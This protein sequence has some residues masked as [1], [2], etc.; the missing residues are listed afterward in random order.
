M[1]AAGMRRRILVV[2]DEDLVRGILDLYLSQA[3]YVVMVVGSGASALARLEEESFDLVLTDHK[4]P[5]MTGTE[6][7]VVIK[8][9]WPALP[10]VLLTG[11]P[12]DE[13]IGA[14]DLILKKP[15]DFR[16]LVPAIEK[17]LARPPS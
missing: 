16:I 8:T 3:G 7:A 5:G 17:L 10:V 1:A 14:L 12:P 13:P 4:M 9:R 2:E 11:F 6:L 15:E